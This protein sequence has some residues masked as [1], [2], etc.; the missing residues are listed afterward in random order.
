MIQLKYKNTSNDSSVS[1]R[2]LSN[3]QLNME[4]GK[5]WPHIVPGSERFS[6]TELPSYKEDFT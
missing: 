6:I 5:V 4:T 1:L 3:L 2:I